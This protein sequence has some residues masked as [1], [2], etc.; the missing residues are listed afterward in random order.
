MICWC[1]NLL[2]SK[3][4]R[5]TMKRWEYI[6]QSARNYIH[7]NGEHAPAW[8]PP[9]DIDFFFQSLIALK[10][11]ARFSPLHENHVY[12]SW[13]PIAK[14]CSRWMFSVSDRLFHWEGVEES[15]HPRFEASDNAWTLLNFSEQQHDH[16]NCLR[17]NS[18]LCIHYHIIHL[19]FLYI[20]C[21]IHVTI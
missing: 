15:P 5:L 18:M 10:S 7:W 3:L 17:H 9:V 4:L 8:E 19:Y 12:S 20:S 14:Q 16:T 1:W 6:Q 11:P 13:W 21:I 2:V